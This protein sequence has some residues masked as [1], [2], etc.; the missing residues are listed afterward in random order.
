MALKADYVTDVPYTAHYYRELNPLWQ[1]FCL[2]HKGFKPPL[3]KSSYLELGMGSGLALAIHAA[4]Q[5]NRH[6]GVDFN[7]T[8]IADAQELADEAGLAIELRCEKFSEYLLTSNLT[9]FGFIA[10]HGVWSWISPEEKDA[11]VSILRRG[12]VPGGVALVTYNAKPGRSAQVPL[13]DFLALYADRLTNQGAG[14]TSQ[15]DEAV[16]RVLDLSKVPTSFFAPYKELIEKTLSSGDS[17][18]RAHEF[19]N[20]HWQPC[21]LLETIEALEPAQMQFA[22]MADPKDHVEEVL[23]PPQAQAFLEEA[24]EPSL[25]SQIKDYLINRSFRRDLF[26]RGLRPLSKEDRQAALRAMPVVVRK[27]PSEF[28]FELTTNWGKTRL[29]RATYETILEAL[30]QAEGVIP[31]G[32]ICD[33]VAD[34]NISIEEVIEAVAVLISLDHIAPAQTSR[35]QEKVAATCGRLNSVLCRQAPAEGGWL[36]SPV[37]GGGEFVER[38]D[39]LF[40]MAENEDGG[41]LP[42][43]WVGD[44]LRSRGETIVKNDMPLDKAAQEKEIES[45]ARRYVDSIRPRL[46]RLGIVDGGKA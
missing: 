17:A 36:A 35:A 2:L 18:Y 31:L 5:P 42:A 32:D 41:R 11:I 34:R 29:N 13:R 4:A 27:S 8:H 16:R 9:Q 44:H 25:R 37:T 23:A 1:R 15:I 21:S 14:L 39:Q 20:R 30:G 19:L 24:G 38:L 33:S 12:L 6:T 22:T 3:E 28:T 7:P 10:L 26:C 46:A 40:L 43:R 45:S